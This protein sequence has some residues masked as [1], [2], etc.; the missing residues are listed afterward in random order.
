MMRLLLFASITLHLSACA[1]GPD[2]KPPAI[3]GAATGSFV[4]MSSAVT[5]DDPNDRW[6]QLYGD[7][8]LDTLIAQALTANTDIRVAVARLDSARAAL[9]QASNQQW[10]QPTFNGSAMYGRR[11]VID[12]IPPNPREGWR[13]DTGID[14]AYELDLFGRLRRHVEAAHGDA[15]AAQEDVDAVRVAVVAETTR[16]YADA[17]S[18]AA[19]IRVARRIVELLDRS[20]RIATER[21]QVGLTT[22]LEPARLAVLREQRRADLASIKAERRT[23]LFRLATLT[24]KAPAALLQTAAARSTALTLG[25][26]IPIGDGARLLARRPDV[27]AAEQRLAAAT[28]RIG[29]VT[30]DLYPKI[31]LGGTIGSTGGMDGIFGAGATRWLAGPLI[32]WDINLSRTRARILGAEAH[33]QAALARFDGIVLRALEETETALATYAQM[34]ERQRV[35]RSARDEAERAAR[36]TR[37]QR[38]E[39]GVDSLAALDAERTLARAEAES[40][41]AD[42]R[43]ADAQVDLFRALGGHWAS[44]SVR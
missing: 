18:A 24:G 19:R 35:L 29:V 33:Q 14:L 30:A 12:T 41:L 16:A 5:A 15:I 40:A 4:T 17:A 3:P 22:E 10:P 42:A 6:W 8:V 11:S 44:A 38:Q 1:V 20:V 31:S 43:I 23:A 34:L 28:A 26:P 9:R 27:R 13:V 39:G 2:F 36:I 37:V 32:R 7:P 25:Q 21:A